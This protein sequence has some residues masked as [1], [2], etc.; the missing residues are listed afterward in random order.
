[1]VS[2]DRL[3]LWRSKNLFFLS[4]CGCCPDIDVCVS[5]PK[6]LHIKVS[7]TVIPHIL[8]E[9]YSQLQWQQSAVCFNDKKAQVVFSYSSSQTLW[10]QR[11]SLWSRLKHL[12]KSANT[13][14]IAM[15]FGAFIHG[16]QKIKPLLTLGLHH[17]EVKPLICPTL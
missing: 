11:P 1:M 10:Q 2:A 3:I 12:D 7:L 15:K 8:N 14:Q 4:C 5:T 9:I 6:I 17:R 16:L 13:G